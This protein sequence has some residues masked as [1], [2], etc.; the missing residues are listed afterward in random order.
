VKSV[1]KNS[2]VIET[3]YSHF[4][5]VLEKYAVKS[6]KPANVQVQLNLIRALFVI[7]NICKYHVFDQKGTLASL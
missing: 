3:L 1:G 2:L 7:G 5:S 6:E 4:Y